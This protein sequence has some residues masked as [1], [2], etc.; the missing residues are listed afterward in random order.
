MPSEHLVINLIWVFDFGKFKSVKHVHFESYFTERKYF[1][2]A[3]I[4]RHFQFLSTRPYC[5]AS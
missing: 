5:Q 2:R 3:N 1:W 4:F